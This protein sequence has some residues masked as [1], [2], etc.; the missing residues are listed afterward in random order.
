MEPEGE[1]APPAPAVEKDLQ[2]RAPIERV[3]EALTE[4]ESIEAWMRSGDVEVDL[5]PGGSYSFFGGE[6]SGVFTR[7]V[8]PHALEY[9]W[10]Q[11]GW[12]GDWPDSV[13]AWDLRPAEGSTRVHLRHT[14]FPNDAEAQSHD[15]GW[16][17]YFL[18]PMR[19]W[20][21]G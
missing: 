4:P 1:T 16:D 13:V 11:A 5:R 15:A 19:S 3:W 21:E 17:E 20:L 18:V 6:T 7:V 9:T 14:V 2:I 10:R 12:A 8:R